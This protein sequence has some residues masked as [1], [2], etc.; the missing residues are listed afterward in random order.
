MRRTGAAYQAHFAL[1]LTVVGGRFRRY[2]VYEDSLAV[3]EAW[4]GL[5]AA[6]VAGPT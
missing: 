5:P 4:H 6:A 3:A 1:H 2:H